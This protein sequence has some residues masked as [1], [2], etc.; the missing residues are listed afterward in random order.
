PLTERKLELRRTLRANLARTLYCQH[1]E[2]NGR[3][4]FDLACEHDL[5]GIVAKWKHGAYT[6]GREETSWVKIR[7]GGYSQWGEERE[8]MFERPDEPRE[9]GAWEGCTAACELMTR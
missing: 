1:I 9:P 7:N 3:A 8:R 5:E 6:G 2:G 4:L